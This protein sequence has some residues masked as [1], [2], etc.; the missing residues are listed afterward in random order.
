MAEDKVA[1]MMDDLQ[2]LMDAWKIAA[3]I[4]KPIVLSL[5]GPSRDYTIDIEGKKITKGKHDKP[6]MQVT[7]K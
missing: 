2:V 4:K 7:I 5:E 1:G 3:E 6:E